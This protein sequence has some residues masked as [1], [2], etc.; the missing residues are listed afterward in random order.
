MHDAGSDADGDAGGRAEERNR[1]G[2]TWNMKSDD[3]RRSARRTLASAVFLALLAGGAGGCEWLDPTEITNPRTTD[4]DLKR[5]ERPVSAMIP[6]LKAQLA[7][8][9]GAVATITANVS[10]SYSIHGTGLVKQWDFPRDINPDVVNIDVGIYSDTQELRALA[11]FTLEELAPEDETATPEQLA[12]VHYFK[13]MGLL[14]LGENFAAAPVEEDGSPLPGAELISRAISAFEASLNQS[15]SGDFALPAKAALARAHR[16]AGNPD[17]A[18]GFAREV[19]AADPAFLQLQQFDPSN[20]T[21]T[22]YWYVYQRALQEMQPLP[23]LDFLDPKYF[24]RAQGIAVAKAEEMHLILAEAA[25]AGGNWAEGREELARAIE[26]AGSRGSSSVEDDDPRKNSDLSIRPRDAEIQVRADPASP[27]RSGLVLDRPG[28]VNVA[29][30]SGTSL[31]ADSVRALSTTDEESLLHA[32]YLARQEIL[33]L[34]GR[35]MSDLGIRIPMWRREMD[36]NR[37]ISAGDPGTSVV[38]PSHIPAQDAMDQFDPHSPYSGDP[39]EL[40]TDQVTIE[41]D[42]NRVLAENRISPFSM[43]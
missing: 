23:R 38:V 4:E 2:D 34:E 37:N 43:P 29:A 18:S 41:V 30:V 15:S 19:L 32:L 11:V 26:V 22:A 17:R 36:T 3:R 9:V 27:Y 39:P 25:M 6:G 31:D 40:Q 10:D 7:R 21:N 13:G 42:M 1:S 33:L 8:S 14:M 28:A 24:G 5:A 20:V 12:A 16:A 35:R